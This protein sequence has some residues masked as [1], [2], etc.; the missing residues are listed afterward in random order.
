[1]GF[2]GPHS[3][4]L[5]S[6]F[7]CMMG[8]IAADLASRGFTGSHEILEAPDGFCNSLAYTPHTEFLTAGLG[9]EGILGRKFRIETLGIKE[10]PV[11]YYTVPPIEAA[12][13][14]MDKHG[15][16][17]EDIDKIIVRTPAELADSADV[18]RRPQHT[19]IE[20]LKNRRENSFMAVLF[21]TLPIAVAIIDRNLTTKQYNDERLLDPKV[22]D[23]AEKVVYTHGG[24]MTLIMLRE[25]KAVVEVEI[26]TK[27]GK[28]YR[29]RKPLQLGG[30]PR[31]VAEKK[32]L[33]EAKRILGEKKAKEVL[34]SIK[35]LEEIKDCSLFLKML[36]T[37]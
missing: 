24:E 13:E 26:R 36:H 10:Y 32:Y 4:L 18:C 6:G 28:R 23:L 7:P 33:A 17:P 29:S 31:E 21:S 8:I 30:Q 9:K 22:H 37:E 12:W 5:S 2:F 15:F 19:N 27:D 16:K 3:K 34:N 1:T 11:C 20:A 25:F 14:L 35:Q